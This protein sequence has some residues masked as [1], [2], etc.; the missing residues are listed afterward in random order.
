MRADMRPSPARAATFGT[1]TARALRQRRR[2]RAGR[3]PGG[4]GAARAVA[5]V[6]SIFLFGL[7][8][9]VVVSGAAGGIVAI[10]GYA[11]FS[12]DLP[13]PRQAL[14]ALVFTQQTKVYDRTG[15][16][17]LATLGTDRRV[18]V[19]FNQIPGELVDATTAIEDHTFWDNSGFDPAGFVSAA[20]DTWKGNDRGGS[21]ITQQLVKTRLLPE[22]AFANGPYERKI[23]EI[24]QAV[25]LTEAYPGPAGKE[26][27]IG[28][29]LNNSFYGNRSYGVAAAARGY[30]GKELK[31]IT[32][33]E[34]AL[35]A[36]I[37][38]S[39]TTFDLVRNA[40]E[41]TYK[42][43]KGVEQTRLVVPMG[44][45]IVTRRNFILELMKTRSVLT[46][47]QYTDADYE[48]AKQEPVILGS[49]ATA[50]WR[51]AQFVWQVRSELGQIL[52]GESQCEK[53]DTG[54][55]R[56]VTTLDYGMQRIVEKW[57]YAAAIIPNSKNQDKVL[58]ARGI[59]RDAWSWI[60]A[61]SG[62]NIHNAAAGVVDYRTGEVLAYA[63][64]ASYTGKG[65][66][67]F[68]PQFDVLSDGWRQPGSS[69]KPLGYLIG[70]E[71]KTM[72]AAT[73]FMDVVTNFPSPGTRPRPTAWSA[74]PCGSGMPCS[75]RSTSPRSRPGTSTASS[76][77]SS[78]PRTSACGTRRA[79][80][81]CRR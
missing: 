10:A 43:A 77:S 78:A 19:T 53:I 79:P 38:Q 49:Q 6:L 51:A 1:H 12:K 45:A 34:A 39:P 4:S 29:Y 64:S 11:Y 72:T 17:L 36:G 65:N 57:V 55:Y 37:P 62:H 48:A 13:D 23:K 67:K 60:K 63:G 25:R 40:V 5:L 41:E 24:I 7:L 31:D 2:L 71:D 3:R 58:K 42:D 9:T 56:V 26:A 50:Q 21:T 47:G 32:L 66:K 70:I 61:L 54:G 69:I 18:L 75:S 8:G 46:V 30:F 59:P 80:S 35:L 44:S 22:S 52:C 74:G 28:A 20:I 76:T 15:A 27:I 68:Q 14:E 73:M 33:A 16:V 81:P